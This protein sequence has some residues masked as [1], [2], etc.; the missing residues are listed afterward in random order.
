MFMHQPNDYHN[1]NFYV[2]KDTTGSGSARCEFHIGSGLLLSIVKG[3]CNAVSYHR[4]YALYVE[5]NLVRNS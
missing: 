5:T 1:F 3:T 4:S 2:G